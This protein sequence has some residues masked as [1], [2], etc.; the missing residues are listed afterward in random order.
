MQRE[1]NKKSRKKL[2]KDVV[3]NTRRATS[4]NLAEEVL[5][6]FK[7]L[8]KDKK[9][10]VTALANAIKARHVFVKDNIHSEPKKSG[11]PELYDNDILLKK[12]NEIL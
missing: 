5:L 9:I 10:G 12:L 7:E 4:R 6:I 1:A 2:V 8:D 3:L 11:V